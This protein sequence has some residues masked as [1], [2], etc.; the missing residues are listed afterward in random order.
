MQAGRPAVGNSQ[1]IVTAS[2]ICLNGSALLYVI[3]LLKCLQLAMALILDG[4]RLSATDLYKLLLLIPTNY[5]KK[6]QKDT[7]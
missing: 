2:E 4:F 5:Q 3:R 7:K 6:V 1:H